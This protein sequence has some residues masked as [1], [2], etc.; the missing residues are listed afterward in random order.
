MGSPTKQIIQHEVAVALQSP[1]L[2]DR[3]RLLGEGKSLSRRLDVQ[4]WPVILEHMKEVLLPLV[5]WLDKP[6]E[7]ASGFTNPPLPREHQ[8]T[9]AMIVFVCERHIDFPRI[10][11]GRDGNWF[12][13]VN[14]DYFVADTAK[15]S[16]FT[17]GR[18]SELVKACLSKELIAFLSETDEVL[19]ALARHYS[20]V[21]FMV[22]CAETV[23]KQLEER[24]RRLA[25]MGERL[26]LF[27]QFGQT[28][29]PIVSRNVAVKFPAFSIWTDHDDRPGTSRYSSDYLTEKA[30]KPLWEN[31]KRYSPKHR[32]TLRL[33]E[34]A[35]SAGSLE[36]FLLR[37][38]WMVEEISK[39]RSNGHMDAKSLCG[40]SE[41]LPFTQEE[42]S[43]IKKLIRSFRRSR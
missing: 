35:Y 4:D 8:K 10:A 16:E 22:Q 32:K 12:I 29:D 11:L 27:S 41:R 37:L 23:S 20:M 21:W 28:L 18:W 26:K 34:S 1:T 3:I 39:T 25:I 9:R 2:A 30:L 38:G 36:R 40:M 5:R 7:G 31:S 6:L 19:L 13:R 33:E 43:V 17:T 15:L 24:E 14:D 42:I